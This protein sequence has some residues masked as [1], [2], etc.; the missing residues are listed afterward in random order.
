MRRFLIEPGDDVSCYA[1]RAGCG[2]TGPPRQWQT[3][4]LLFRRCRAC[5]KPCRCNGR[6]SAIPR[7]HLDKHTSRLLQD[8]E[9][10]TVHAPINFWHLRARTFASFNHARTPSRLQQPNSL[11]SFADC[12]INRPELADLANRSASRPLLT[13][14]VAKLMVRAGN[15]DRVRI[16]PMLGSSA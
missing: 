6:A 14:S 13:S 9:I 2:T 10:A 11:A 12:R 3:S 15:P 16:F 1:A 4:R 7:E 8:T 5:A